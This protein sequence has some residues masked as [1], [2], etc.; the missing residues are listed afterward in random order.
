MPLPSIL[1]VSNTH[2]LAHD[3]VH[4]YRAEDLVSDHQNTTLLCLCFSQVFEGILQRCG[5]KPP[6]HEGSPLKLAERDGGASSLRNV[7]LS[8]F[9]VSAAIT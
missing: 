7:P 2:T 6:S 4:M 8:Q 5:V 3:G 1:S 9:Q